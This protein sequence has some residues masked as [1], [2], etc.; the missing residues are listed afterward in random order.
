MK[1]SKQISFVIATCIGF[2]S[3]LAHAEMYKCLNKAGKTIYQANKCPVDAKVSVVKEADKIK[4][5]EPAPAKPKTLD[6][7]I[8][9]G[10]QAAAD[11]DKKIKTTNEEYDVKIALLKKQKVS[12]YK[13][14]TE[15]SL[16]L[17]DLYT[18]KT[19]AYKSNLAAVKA[20]EKKINLQTTA[21]EKKISDIKAKTAKK[22]PETESAE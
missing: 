19:K 7:V 18:E 16:A 3:L 5:A 10:K 17:K 21:I 2:W 9:D 11:I 4:R 13:L 12:T 20:E 6:S 14:E 15:K 1:T 22:T 8:A